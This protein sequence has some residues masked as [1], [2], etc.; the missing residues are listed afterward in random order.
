MTRSRTAAPQST[1]TASLLYNPYQ[2][3]F[4]RALDLRLEDGRPAYS[5]LALFA[6]RRGGKTLIGGLATVKRAVAREGQT[7]WVATGSY[8]KLHD[9]VIPAVK[10]FLP[11]TFLAKPFSESHYE[12]TL[13]NGTIIQ[14]R[15]LDDVNRARGPGLDLAW[16]DEARDVAQVAWKTM[17]PALTDKLGS[18]IITTTPSGFDWCFESFWMPA[19][20]GTPGY[21]ACKYRTSEN[22]LYQQAGYREELEAARRDMDPLFYQQEFEAEFVSFTGAIY[23]DVLAPQMLDTDEQIRRFIPEWPHIAATRPV[24]VGLDPGADHP[25]AGVVL[26]GTEL[27]LL[28]VAEYLARDGAAIKHAQEL[29]SVLAR[30]H[31]TGFPTWAIDRSQRQMAIE[32]AQ[33]GIFTSGAEND[34]VAGIQRVKSW[35]YSKRLFL[36]RPRCPKL[37]QQLF[38][39]RWAE[40]TDSHGAARRESVV[41]VNDDL[42]DALRYA[43]MSWPETMYPEPPSGLRTL[44]Q[45]PDDQRWALE[46]LQRLDHPDLFPEEESDLDLPGLATEDGANPLGHFW[47]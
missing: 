45:V 8:P 39:Y 30:A 31:I 38:S 15:S 32:L 17:V 43:I 33:H 21:W 5:R 23:G 46:R 37:V 3:E 19:A 16:I 6:G 22:P 26:V 34:V 36:V 25:F 20:E 42:P 44:T 10:R 24:V 7:I 29:H 18:V 13:T 28:V 41:K 2:Q 14:A 12:W 40:N 1:G 27:G 9:Y 4:L 35:L 47:D 11:A